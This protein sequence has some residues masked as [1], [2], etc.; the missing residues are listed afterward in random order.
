MRHD[1]ERRGRRDPRGPRG[2]SGGPAEQSPGVRRGGRDSQPGR[3]AAPLWR[4][5]LIAPYC[6]SYP[7]RVPFRGGPRRLRASGEAFPAPCR[8]GGRGLGGRLPEKQ[9]REIRVSRGEPRSPGRWLHH[10][11]LLT[12]CR[13]SRRG[14]GVLCRPGFALTL[15]TLPP[16][17]PARWRI[18]ESAPRCRL[19]G[20]CALCAAGLVNCSLP[21]AAIQTDPALQRGRGWRGNCGLLPV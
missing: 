21:G 16:S 4:A 7:D 2:G 15:L 11:S 20:S 17:S 5:V 8:P 19:V 12:G 3:P 14:A 6:P 18:R 13:G 9:S 1:P 10:S